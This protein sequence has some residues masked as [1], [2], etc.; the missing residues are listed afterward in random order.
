LTKFIYNPKTCRFEKEY[1]PVARVLYYICIVLV[2]A[3]LFFWGINRAHGL[4]VETEAEKR[5]KAENELLE[6]YYPLVEQQLVEAEN[7]LSAIEE[8]DQVL[9]ASLFSN[10]LPTTSLSV[11]QSFHKQTRSI[12]DLRHQIRDLS[13]ATSHHLKD[14]SFNSVYFSEQLE[15]LGTITAD[16][17]KYIP[18]LNPLSAGM[19]VSGFG[20]RLN[21]F[22]KGLYDHPGIDLSAP[23]GTPV[24]ASANGTIQVAQ[25]SDLL[26][27]YGNYIDIQHTEG[28]V[29][30]Y[31]H[32]ETISVRVGQRITKGQVIGTVGMSGG[33]V[34]PHLHYEVLRNGVEQNPIHFIMEGITTRQY[35]QLLAA[36][37][38]QN[39][40]LD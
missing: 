34:A 19:L 3:G 33:A 5:L 4:L 7:S 11:R 6:K 39:Q 1:F 30:R 28:I 12:D 13:E 17:V 9:K 2:L 26:A 15:K 16:E 18:S 23:R 32:L 36:S 20:K 24:V 29:T 31:A 27:G 25:R 38:K 37:K 21:P 14:A 22:H 40:S 10:I 35:E 8:K